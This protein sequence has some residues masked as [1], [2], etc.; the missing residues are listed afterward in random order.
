MV[1]KVYNVALHASLKRMTVE[2][3]L[4]KVGKAIQKEETRNKRLRQKKWM[5]RTAEALDKLDRITESRATWEKMI[6][7][8]DEERIGNPVNFTI[9]PEIFN[10]A[11]P[12]PVI[13]K[14]LNEW[15][16][17]EEATGEDTAQ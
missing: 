17:D 2:A 13:E 3:T 11:L 10:L 8:R 6:K 14:T 15:K 16:G 1:K 7:K 4:N 12:D 9:D 5:R